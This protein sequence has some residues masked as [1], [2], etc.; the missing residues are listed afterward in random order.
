VQN[1]LLPVQIPTAMALLMFSGS[2]IGALFLSFSDTIF[3]NSLK[4]LIPEYAP[5]VD[6]QSVINAG[7]TG[8]RAILN[9]SELINV[10]IAYSKSVDRVYYL[11]SGAT[12]G[13]FVFSWAM[14][15]KDIRKK[16]PT[17]AV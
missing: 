17:S 10:L 12:V 7:A 16:S 5:S 9:G 14:G 4:T 15:W 2:F 1:T 8:F 13:C 11:I 6:A 3:T